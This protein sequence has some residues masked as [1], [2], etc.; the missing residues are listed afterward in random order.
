MDDALGHGD[1]DF[2]LLGVV[3]HFRLGHGLV[4]DDVDVQAGERIQNAVELVGIDLDIAQHLDDFFI[5]QHALGFPGLNQ[6]A[7]ALFHGF[8]IVLYS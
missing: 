4:L 7:Y 3:E 5:R 1:V 8:C 6:F 2:L